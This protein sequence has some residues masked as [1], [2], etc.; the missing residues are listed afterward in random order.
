MKKTKK[1]LP[2]LLAASIAV[3]LCACG[4]TPS[5]PTP[6]PDAATETVKTGIVIEATMHALTIEARDG[7]T[8]SFVTDDSTEFTGSGEDL[9]DT[10]S[11]GYEGEYQQNA[12]AKVI[13]VVEKGAE[14]TVTPVP[15][16]T[17][18]SASPASS[19]D[20]DTIKYIIAVVKDASMHNM[21][22]SWQDKDY[23]I[24]KDDDTTVDGAIEVGN[25]VRIFHYGDITDGI[26]ALRIDLMVEDGDDIKYI[27]G[28]V[29]DASMNNICV[30]Y[31]GH[32]YNISKDDD[33]KSDSVSVGDQVRVYH[34]GDIQDGIVATRIIKL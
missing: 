3:S 8:Y 32:Q 7:S 4:G 23:L 30:D 28:E 12:L 1:I 21:T 33:T 20:P 5:A 26:T 25:T 18:A 10:V 31:D 15:E 24:L 34:H 22:V 2:L 19:T 16:A 17:E 13:K 27:N 11:V 6:T 9:G 29:I 14:G